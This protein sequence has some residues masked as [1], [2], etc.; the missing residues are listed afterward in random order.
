M[1][2]MSNSRKTGQFSTTALQAIN[3]ETEWGLYSYGICF[4]QK[5]T[6]RVSYCNGSFY[7]DSLLR[8]LSSWTEHSRLVVHHCRNSSV[9]S[10]LSALL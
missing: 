3:H 1:R 10:L 5:N 9:P 7:D 2:P 6:S 8:S 4:H